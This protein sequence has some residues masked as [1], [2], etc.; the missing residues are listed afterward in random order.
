LENGKKWTK[1]ANKR[2]L[3]NAIE[4]A[5]INLDPA[6][7]RVAFDEIVHRVNKCIQVNGNLYIFY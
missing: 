2:S 4:N 7:M 1:V 5:A 3:K 6:M